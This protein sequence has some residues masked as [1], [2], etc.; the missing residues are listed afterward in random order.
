MTWNISRIRHFGQFWYLIL[1]Y[2]CIEE[3]FSCQPVFKSYKSDHYKGSYGWPF[4]ADNIFEGE[5]MFYLFLGTGAWQG[6]RYEVE[7]MNV[8]TNISQ[9]YHSGLKTSLTINEMANQT[10]YHV[11]VRAFS[12][13]GTGPWSSWFNGATLQNGMESTLCFR[14]H[15]YNL[16]DGLQYIAFCLSTCVMT[17]GWTILNGYLWK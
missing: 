1:S 17:S 12:E 9:L 7:I 6:W 10:A 8:S 4:K 15:M 2:F 3:V 13:T 5:C 14:S 11:R 16:H